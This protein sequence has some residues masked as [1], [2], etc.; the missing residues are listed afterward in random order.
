M[1]IIAT[2]IPTDLWNS[3]VQ[4]FVNDNWE[5]TYK[6]FHFDAGIDSDFVLLEKENE[7]LLFG[8]DN[9]FEG[10]ILCSEKRMEEIENLVQTK[11]EKGEPVN[12]KPAVVRLYREWKEK[13][14]F[15]N[16]G[17]LKKKDS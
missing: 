15:N 17:L 8:W 13:N 1:M 5:V 3:I 14:N 11:F 9:W 7:E 16:P 6:Y 4:R 2:N 12:L 10:E